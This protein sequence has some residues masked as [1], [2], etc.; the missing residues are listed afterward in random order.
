M[1]KVLS[2]KFYDEMKK[3]ESRY[4]TKVALLL[5]ALHSAQEEYGWIAPEVM[6]EIGALIGI[7]PAQ[8]KEVASFYSMYYMKP[9]GK[10]Q[11]RICTNVACALRGA[12]DLVVYCEKKLGIQV[13]QTTAD[14][15]FSLFE[16]ECLGA[17]GTAPAMM[18]DNKEYFENLDTRKL[19][20][21]IGRLE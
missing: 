14:R 18:L 20:E 11:L 7:H 19:D 4:P 21:I 6:D 1:A 12:E 5:P 9:V 13:G 2:Q 16:E 3:L 17:C 10:H 8:V 15:K